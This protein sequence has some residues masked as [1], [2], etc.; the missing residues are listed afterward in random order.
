M[1]QDTIEPIARLA[2]QLGKLPGIGGKTA[3]RLAYHIVMLPEEQVR[4]LSQCVLDAKQKTRSCGIC[5]ALTDQ[6]PCRIC[7]DPKREEVQLCV[8]ETPRDVLA[9]ERTR[10]YRGKYHVLGGTLS[11]MDGIG[12]EQLRIKA[13]IARLSDGRIQEVILANN[14]TVEGEATAS[15]LARLIQPMG[16]RVTRIAHGVP[17]GSDIEYADEITL[18]LALKGRRSMDS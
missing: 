13:L 16:L 18:S 17:V 9:M 10:E 15:Y 1:I 3:R 6:D 4:Q 2:E 14:P 8:V 12:P 7:A 11:P 5:G